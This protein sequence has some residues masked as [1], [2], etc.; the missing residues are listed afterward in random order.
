M[1]KTGKVLLIV[2][3]GFG[4]GPDFTFNAITRSNMPFYQS[5]LKKQP[6]TIL[7]TSGEAVGLPPGVMGNSEVGHMNIGAGRIVYQELTRIDRDI[8]NGDFQKDKSILALFDAIKSNG[9]N[10]RLHLFG[11]L[12]DGGVH[13]HIR[14]FEAVLKMAAAH[15]VPT[16]VHVFTDGRDTPPKS[17]IEYAV[18]LANILAGCPQTVVGSVSGRYYAMD[19]DKRWDRLQQAWDVLT[20]RSDST[21]GAT[22]GNLPSHSAPP[23]DHR[24]QGEPHQSNGCAEL[25]AY[26]ESCYSKDLT[27]EFL[28]PRQL[29]PS[30]GR[31]FVADGDGVFFLNFRADRARQLTAAFVSDDLL[32]L[33]RGHRPKLVSFLTMTQYDKTLPVPVVYGPQN[34]S[35]LLPDVL[36]RRGLSQFRIAETEKYAHVTFFFNGSRETPYSGESR[37]LIP[38]PKDVATYDLKPEMSAP[39]VTARLVQELEHGQTDFILVNFANADMVGHTGNFDAAVKAMEYLDHCLEKVVGAATKSGYSVLITADHGNVEEMHEY[40]HPEQIH[41]QHTLNPVP[42]I[43]VSNKPGLKL[44]DGGVL[45][46]VAPTILQVMGIEQPQAMTGHSLLGNSLQKG[47]SS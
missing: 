45:A 15:H 16:T 32:E 42:L 8:R 30:S 21:A 13:A 5:L 23:Q 14:H 41:T 17:G 27:D 36:A 40:D 3:D 1:T 18:Q 29:Q 7:Q 10:S 38:S 12:S 2:L 22:A 28:P 31:T 35:D 9:P 43:L 19:R 25:V 37:A 33:K 11:L 24:V 39:E 4:E 6:H 26:L 34:L 46:D 47:K 44:S 20:K